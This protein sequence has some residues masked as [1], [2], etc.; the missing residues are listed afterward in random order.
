MEPRKAQVERQGPSDVPSRAH[1]SQRAPGHPGSGAGANLPP[2]NLPQVPSAPCQS[3]NLFKQLCQRHTFKFRCREKETKLCILPRP[4][5][6]VS[7]TL[8]TDLTKDVGTSA[9]DI[10]P[11]MGFS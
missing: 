8:A 5:K 3:V 4:R 6:T 9:Y 11:P 7:S 10:L 2:V 1:L